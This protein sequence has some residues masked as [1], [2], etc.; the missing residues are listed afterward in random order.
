MSGGGTFVAIVERYA[1]ARTLQQLAACARDY[2][3]AGAPHAPAWPKIRL[4]LTGNY[5]TQFLARGF[6]VALAARNFAAE[7]YES[8]YNQWRPEIL[9]AA[10][11]LHAFAPTHIILALTSIELAY[12]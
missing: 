7:I 9:E 12:G 11:P 4:A 3:A 10:S 6:P 2:Q 8:P 5:S 1:A